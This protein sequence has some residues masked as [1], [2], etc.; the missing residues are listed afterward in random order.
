MATLIINDWS[1]EC[2]ACGKSADPMEDAHRTDLYRDR[3]GCGERFTATATRLM[4]W[5]RIKESIEEMRPDLPFTGLYDPNP[6]IG[7]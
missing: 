3:P 7:C 6:K 5:R 1:S 4:P 2:S